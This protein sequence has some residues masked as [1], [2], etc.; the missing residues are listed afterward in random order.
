MRLSVLVLLLAMAGAA[1]AAAQTYRSRNPGLER[2]LSE[3]LRIGPYEVTE[4]RALVFPC[5]PV[6]R[7][8]AS[9]P[10]DANQLLLEGPAAAWEGFQ[11]CRRTL[12]ADVCAPLTAL[13]EAPRR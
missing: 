11:V 10:L 13:F 6:G 5:K 3:R 4:R 1:G 8:C 9:N 7:G 2:Q 12:S